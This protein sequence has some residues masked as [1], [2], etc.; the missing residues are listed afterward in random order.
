MVLK[1]Q[2]SYGE[3]RERCLYVIISVDKIHGYS[4]RT[5]YFVAPQESKLAFDELRYWY[6]MENGKIVVRNRRDFKNSSGFDIEDQSV[7]TSPIVVK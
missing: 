6:D 2:I 1:Y 4:L 5:A 3:D 7:F